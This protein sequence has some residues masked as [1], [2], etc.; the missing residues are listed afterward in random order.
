MRRFPYPKYTEDILTS[1][2]LIFVGLLFML[3]F[4]YTCI[5]IVKAITAEKE[6]QLKVNY[7]HSFTY[8]CYSLKLILL[9][10][11]DNYGSTK[12]VAL[13]GMVCQI[14]HFINNINR[15]YDWIYENSMVSKFKLHRIYIFRFNSYISVSFTLRLF[16]DYFLFRH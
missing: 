7:E 2:L 14:I 10:I 16:H 5:N 11:N 12:L 3:S 1:A 13:D 9:A 8:Y 6:N 15:Y 4:V